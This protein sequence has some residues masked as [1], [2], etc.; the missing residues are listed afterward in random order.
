MQAV[1]IWLL[2]LLAL[3]AG[4][5]FGGGA[6]SISILTISVQ[7]VE[8]E[9]IEG[10]DI[11]IG[12]IT[13]Q[14]GADGRVRLSG[15]SA[16]SRADVDVLAEGYHPESLRISAPHEGELDVVLVSGDA[17]RANFDTP[18]QIAVSDT[19][20]L[21]YEDVESVVIELYKEGALYDSHTMQPEQG[22]EY[23]FSAVAAGSYYVR[24]VVNGQ[25]SG[26]SRS[27]MVTPSYAL[28]FYEDNLKSGVRV[29]VYAYSDFAL[30]GV[31]AELY[32]DEDGSAETYL[33]P[34]TYWY[35]AA[36]FSA[37]DAYAVEEGE[38]DLIEDTA[39][40]FEMAL[41][42]DGGSGSAQA[43]YRISNWHHLANAVHY[44]VDSGIHHSDETHFLMAANLDKTSEGYESLVAAGTGWQPLGSEDHPFDGRFWGDGHTIAG[45]RVDDPSM[46]HAGLFGYLRDAMVT[47]LVLVEAA[48]YGASFTGILAGRGERSQVERINV[49]GRAAGQ[50]HVGGLIGFWDDGAEHGKA[51]TDERLSGPGINQCTAHADIY[52]TMRVG[53]LVGSNYGSIFDSSS[54]GVVQGGD[55]VGG[56]IG[57]NAGGTVDGCYAHSD[58]V[59]GAEGVGGLVG[60]H[61]SVGGQSI[62]RRSYAVATVQG[63]QYVGGLVGDVRAEADDVRAEVLIHDAY[64]K[65]NVQGLDFVGGL[66]GRGTGRAAASDGSK[67]EA[68]LWFQHTYA[69]ATVTAP[70][71]ALSVGAWIGFDDVEGESL[72]GSVKATIR[73]I[74]NAYSLE[75]SGPGLSD[76]FAEPKTPVELRT[77]ETFASGRGEERWDFSGTWQIEEGKT[78]PFLREP[79]QDPPPGS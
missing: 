50:M 14:T 49:N 25:T 54:Q 33:E 73:A 77:Q 30:D 39:I 55:H 1:P 6:D 28:A 31:V 45:L 26:R 38:I 2:T 5:C 32:T 70:D 62:L 22:T 23:V 44:G 24:Q 35:R 27:G 63:D 4:G 52:G 15:L 43:P 76:A 17:P 71:E 40:G 58:L 16:G 3:L 37:T 9:P 34:G 10:A 53:G 12:G 51:Y 19:A 21:N 69:A 47:D 41:A 65:A 11:V 59:S 7:D 64:A 48:V 20:D 57:I 29:D 79:K 42:F 46:E 8:G 78:L 13:E 67:A 75:A 36:V 66:V 74:G 56:L 72:N 18:G 61:T 60:S 68:G